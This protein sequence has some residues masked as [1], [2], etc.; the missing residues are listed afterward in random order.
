MHPV[1]LQL[2]AVKWQLFGKFYSAVDVALNLSY[3]LL[4]TIL[5]VSLPK[6][7]EKSYYT[8]LNK[9][10][11]RI[12]LEFGSVCMAIYFMVKVSELL[13]TFANNYF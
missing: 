11:W 10:A 2:I 4:W 13:D 8:P 1:I 6:T 12:V 7:K 3:T 9:N 5:G